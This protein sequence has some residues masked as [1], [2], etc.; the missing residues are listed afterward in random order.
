MRALQLLRLFVLCLPL[1]ALA[2]E[3]NLSGFISLGLVASDNPDYAF[4]RDIS[5]ASGSYDDQLRWRNDSLLGL[6]WQGRWSYQLDT[7]LQLVAKDRVDNT[8]EDSLEWAF[9]HY[10]P[11]DSWDLRL[12]RMGVDVFMLSEYREV[13]Y[14]FPWVRPPQDVYG[15]LSLYRVDGLDL[16]KRFDLDA[17]TLNLKLF[18]GRS[19][20]TYPLDYD[21]KLTQTLDFNPSG[22]SLNLE[23]QDWKLR[24]SYAQVRVNNNFFGPLSQALEQLAPVWPEASALAERVSTK[25]S[26]FSYQELGL[27]YDSRHWWLQS[28]LI[29]L[30]SQSSLI[31]DSRLYYLSLGRHF[32]PWLVYLNR[33]RAQPLNQA[34]ALAPPQGYPEPLNSQL[35][36]IN[37]QLN[38]LLNSARLDQRSWGLG[39]RWD[40]A[41]RM[42]LKLQLNQIDFSASGSNLWLPRGQVEEDAQDSRVLSLSWDAIF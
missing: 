27:G 24:Y 25:D 12:G 16:N 2:L 17:A 4:R 23:L 8:L 11:R 1:P 35:Q 14:A 32:G 13:G 29:A 19:R 34:I 39:L 31:A 22:L 18:Y 15:L 33:G 20:E 42:A 38:T 28:E 37:L 21:A 5:Q 9:V 26:H 30:R 3:Q 40:F 41:P 6:K 7:T 10:R 36:A